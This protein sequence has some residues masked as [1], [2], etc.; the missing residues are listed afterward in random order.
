M[1][2]CPDFCL[3]T[4]LTSGQVFRWKKWVSGSGRRPVP[5]AGFSGWIDGSPVRISQQNSTLTFEGIS[6]D[7]IERFFSLD[8]DLKEITR[9]VDVDETIHSAIQNHWGLRL[10]RQDPWEC[11]VS[12]I[13]SSFNN[14][15]RL[16]GMLETLAT[17]FGEQAIDG[18][19]R[20]FP[21]AERL[22]KISERVL[23]NCGLGFRAPYVKAAARAVAQ[24]TVNLEHLRSLEDE[25]LRRALLAVPGVGEKVVECVMLFGYGRAAAF[26]VDVWIGRAMRA[27]YFRR[28]KATDRKIREFA[29]KHFGPQCGWAQQYLYCRARSFRKDS[30]FLLRRPCPRE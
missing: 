5:D 18:Q 4:T 14:I 16:T 1:L 8:V 3:A 17:R 19:R 23:R 15:P 21:R 12:F 29:R 9:Q 2:S 11:L 26:P 20:W 10:I 24:G 6:P 13:L 22:V 30:G 7:R 27:W 25:P 28:R